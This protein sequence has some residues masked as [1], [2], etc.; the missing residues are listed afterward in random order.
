MW[1]W[2]WLVLLQHN[3]KWVFE[4]IVV[5]N[6]I[7]VYKIYVIFLQIDILLITEKNNN[8][9]QNWYNKNMINTT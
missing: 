3:N 6:D 5:I 1:K 2:L 4:L 8:K 9:C 7:L